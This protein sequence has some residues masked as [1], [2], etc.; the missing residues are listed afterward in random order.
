MQ[1]S[2]ALHSD[3]LNPQLSDDFSAR[4]SARLAQEPTVIAPAQLNISSDK[5]HAS[6]IAQKSKYIAGLAAISAFVF[7]VTNQ[8]G[9]QSIAPTNSS[10]QVAQQMMTTD[11]LQVNANF[12]PAS[13]NDFAPKMENQV[14]MLRDPSLDSY[15]MAH[16]K[17]SPSLDNSGRYIQKAKIEKHDHSEAQK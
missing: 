4:F 17:V 1:I 10:E 12:E 16:Q 15:L 9:P 7:V 2:D 5:K 8:M 13:A 3:E 11:V 6:W 14:E